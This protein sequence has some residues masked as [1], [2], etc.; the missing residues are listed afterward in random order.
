MY[1]LHHHYSPLWLLRAFNALMNLSGLLLPMALLAASLV[2]S[3]R[4]A[5]ITSLE[6]VLPLLVLLTFGLTA[7]IVT[8][9]FFTEIVSDA[10][11]LRIRFLWKYLVVRWDEVV[12]VKP[13][14]YL[15]PLRSGSWVVRTR[16]LTP[17]HRLYGLLYGFTLSPSFV[18]LKGM[19]NADELSRRIRA[20]VKANNKRPHSE[21]N[22]DMSPGS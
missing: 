2:G 5:R 1:P 13:M 6:Q 15:V 9:N 18:Y 21:P 8:G 14:F 3:E 16:A 4:N 22:A 20:A 19:S 11:G 10:D 7:G 12:E 17:F